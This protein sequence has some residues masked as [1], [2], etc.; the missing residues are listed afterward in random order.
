M[1]MEWLR[2][3]LSV[4]AASRSNEVQFEKAERFVQNDCEHSG[5]LY[6]TVISVAKSPD[7]SGALLRSKEFVR[8]RLDGSKLPCVRVKGYSKLLTNSAITC[9]ESKVRVFKDACD[10]CEDLDRRSGVRT[11]EKVFGSSTGR[12]TS[13]T[14]RI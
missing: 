6:V 14:S 5:T 10:P 8:G 12:L 9:L 3:S 7:W 4:A 2:S 13:R 11:V 1:L